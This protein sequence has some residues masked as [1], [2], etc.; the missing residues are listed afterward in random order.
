MKFKLTYRCLL[1]NELEI[2]GDIIEMTQEQAIDIVGKAIQNQLF[3]GNPALH[4]APL[5][6]GHRCRNGGAGLA[7]FAGF[8]RIDT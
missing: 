4:K 1:C 8:M 6:V 3:A 2:I 5:H 7:Q